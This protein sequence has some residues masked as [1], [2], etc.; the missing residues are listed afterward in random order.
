[1]RKAED[2]A[3]ELVATEDEV[4]SRQMTN[5]FG[6]RAEARARLHVELE[7]A[8]ARLASLKQELETVSRAKYAAKG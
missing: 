2:I 7:D 4:R 3:A 1:M 8:F 6:L 5:I